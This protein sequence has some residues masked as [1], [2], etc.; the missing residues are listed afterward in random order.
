VELG[1]RRMQGYLYSEPLAPAEIPGLVRSLAAAVAP[2][3]TLREPH[4][5]E[6]IG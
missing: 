4:R 2:A 6:R 5:I 3:G 1:C